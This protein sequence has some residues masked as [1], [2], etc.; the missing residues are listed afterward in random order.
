MRYRSLSLAALALSS[1]ALAGCVD[2]PTQPSGAVEARPTVP[3]LAVASNTWITRANMPANRTNLATA[4]ITN[5]AGQSV[6]YAIGGLNPNRVPVATVT[7]YNVATNTW[8]FR[9]TLPVPLAGSNGAGVINGKIYVSG[10]YSDYGGDFPSGRLYMYDPAT[11]TWTRKRDIPMVTSVPGIPYSDEYYAAGD[12]VTG[13][14]NG[15]LYVVSGCFQA[16]DPWGYYE[17]CNPLFFRYN[18]ATDRWTRLPSPFAK[19]TYA[20][21]IGGVIAGKFYVMAN[22]GDTYNAYFAVYDPVT[23]RW[24]PRN[25]LG[26]AHSG[27]G[28][29]VLG[30]KLY[31][32]GGTRYNAATDAFDKVMLTSVYDPATNLWTRR[33]NMPSA[34]TDIAASNV[35][36]NGKPRIEVVGGIAPGNNIQ[37]IP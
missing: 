32:I 12:G 14:I 27:A 16:Q 23:N 17:T 20:P 18:P 25:S 10:G 28:S 3:E 30:G 35:L 36:L 2:E 1:L 29:A 24:T 8:T 26:L 19:P 34:R 9:R 5:A 22:S 6:V 4:T 21:S 7:A 15:K 37:Y 11:N 31:V 13:V 33:A